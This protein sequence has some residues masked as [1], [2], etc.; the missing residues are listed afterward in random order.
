MTKILKGFIFEN[1]TIFQRYFLLVYSTEN[2][3]NNLSCKNV[4]K[5]EKNLKKKYSENL[6]HLW[7]WL[8]SDSHDSIFCI[9]TYQ[10]L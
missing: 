4:E 8:T 10:G 5:E 7:K 2:F 1:L 6:K 3:N 9:W